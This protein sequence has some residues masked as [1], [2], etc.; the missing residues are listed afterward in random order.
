MASKRTCVI[1]APA[2]GN[3]E[4]EENWSI[5]YD[6]VIYACSDETLSVEKGGNDGGDFSL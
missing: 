2:E 3:E 1:C 5:R 4:W 6:L